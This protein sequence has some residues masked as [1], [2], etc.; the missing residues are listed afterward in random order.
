LLE[1]IISVA[2]GRAGVGEIQIS[3][4]KE[5]ED[6]DVRVI[7]ALVYILL[8]TA[9]EV[10][11]LYGLPEKYRLYPAVTVY[12]KDKMYTT[13]HPSE[14]R[15]KLKEG[16]VVIKPKPLSVAEHRKAY[17]LLNKKHKTAYP[18]KKEGKERY[19]HPLLD[20]ESTGARLVNLGLE[21]ITD[22]E[23]K[24]ERLKRLIQLRPAPDAKPKEKKRKKKSKKQSKKERKEAKAQRKA[25]KKAKGKKREHKGKH[26]G[27]PEKEKK[28]DKPEVYRTSIGRPAVVIEFNTQGSDG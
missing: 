9:E 16:V 15:E 3:Y 21:L 5:I 22:D 17:I 13:A 11:K 8:R 24:K 18:E 1:A 27:K 12:Y 26:E 28:K 4:G 25:K 20:V 6:K 23:V 10:Y 19:Y 2:E 7:G 14:V